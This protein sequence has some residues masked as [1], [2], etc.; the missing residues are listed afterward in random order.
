MIEAD[1][2][3]RLRTG[4]A[5]GVATRYLAREDARTLGVFG[6]GGQAETQIEAVAAVRPL[7]TVLAFSRNADRASAFCGRMTAK[8]GLTV[9]PATPEEVAGQDIVCTI[10][11]SR[12]PV[13][14]GVWLHEGAHVNA[15]GSNWAHRR[16]LDDE[17]IRRASL[18]TCD[19][20]AQATIEAGDLIA[21]A[22]TG[23]LDW[24]KVHSLGEVIS[25]QRQGRATASDIT[26]FKSLGIGAED[27]AFAAHV[28]ERARALGR[29]D[30]VRFHEP[31][32]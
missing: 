28:Y 18:I 15:A 25:G 8:L 3:G 11:T 5:S 7:T 21:P 23:V 32:S 19:D 14:R 31:N 27:V 24:D 9:R 17:A 4:A 16:E 30:T 13:C 12:D 10:T 22:K 1:W 20:V 6:T 29:G 26:L 2:L